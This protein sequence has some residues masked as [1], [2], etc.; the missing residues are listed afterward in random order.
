MLHEVAFEHTET[1]GY[2]LTDGYTR[3]YDDK[4]RPTVAFVEFK[5]RF[6]VDISLAGAGFH[7][8]IE[9]HRSESVG[10][11]KSLR[12]RHSRACLHGVEV[13]E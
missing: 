6:D 5:H 4:L 8:H 2:T 11:G 12:E 13:F 7:L 9:A 1:L 3:H 10:G